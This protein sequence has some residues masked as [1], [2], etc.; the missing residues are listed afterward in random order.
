MVGLC[1]VTKVYTD[2]L[3]LKQLYDRTVLKD[4]IVGMYIQFRIVGLCTVTKGYTDTLH[5]Y[6]LNDRTVLKVMIKGLCIITQKSLQTPHIC[7][8]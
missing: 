2:T 5:L 6:E 3:Y 8:N 1:I 7:R 4:R